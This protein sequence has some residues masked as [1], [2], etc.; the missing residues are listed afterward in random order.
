MLN[1]TVYQSSPQ[2]GPVL[3]FFSDLLLECYDQG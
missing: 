1:E 3:G 2:I